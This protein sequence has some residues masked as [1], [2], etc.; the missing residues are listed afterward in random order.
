MSAVITRIAVVVMLALCCS[1]HA[2]YYGAADWRPN[3]WGLPAPQAALSRFPACQYKDESG[4]SFEVVSRGG[5]DIEITLPGALQAGKA[6]QFSVW[7]KAAKGSP[8][9][10]LF[11]RSD[12]A[13]YETWAVRTVSLG[14]TWTRVQLHG[15]STGLTVGSVRIAS[16]Q[17]GAAVCIG[18]AQIEPMGM[19]AVG[20]PIRPM[21]VTPRLFGVHLNQLGTHRGWPSFNPGIV[22][23]WDSGTTWADL[24]PTKRPIDWSSVHGRRLDL[25]VQHIKKNNPQGNVLFTLAMTPVW[26]GSI[27][28]KRCNDSSYGPGSCTAPSDLNDWRD[29]VR[30]VVTRYAKDIRYWEVWN[31]ADIWTQ[32]DG[33]PQRMFDLV[34][35]AYEEIKAIDP[36]LVVIGP[37]VTSNGLRF[38]NE[39]LVAGGARYVDALSVHAYLERDPERALSSL[40]NVQETANA[41]G[42]LPPLWNTESGIS[43]TSAA[44]Q[45]GL[46]A[47][48]T[49]A[50]GLIGSAA[51][52]VSNFNYYTWEGSGFVPLVTSDFLTSTSTGVALA[53]VRRWINGA[54][55]SYLPD[56][57]AGMS[58][59]QIERDGTKAYVAWTEKDSGLLSVTAIP[60]ADR[61]Q[62]LLIRADKAV[63][64][65]SIAVG[66]EP[67][68]FFG[69]E[70]RFDDSWVP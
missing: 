5:G 46:S 39:F 45:G 7:L 25:Y 55:L 18:P 21:K 52:G 61:Y 27:H 58:L 60:G 51:L 30:S 50:Q 40:R 8:T 23:L 66:T 9:V 54:T 4:L 49:L 56:P 28:S 15:I 6:Y 38:L 69:S 17:L 33:S 65:E 42:M 13:P 48:T 47:E 53:R 3:A 67:T 41:Y 29:Y 12:A 32:W 44:T 24:Q 2:A 64:G 68:L 22:R 57:V 70:F 19:H 11:Y 63:S 43:A 37:N 20:V 10:D 34:R 59:I 14:A 1:A 62:T 36:T 26:A 31:E 16:R 35:A